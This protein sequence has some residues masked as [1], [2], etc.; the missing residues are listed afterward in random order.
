LKRVYETEAGAV[1]RLAYDEERIAAVVESLAE[2]I[3]A[4]YKGEQLLLI[5]VLKG[6]VV[7]AADLARRLRLPVTLDFVGLSSYR[8]TAST[9]TVRVTR[10]IEAAVAGRHVLVIEDIVDT[11][12]TLGF[13]LEELRAR[14][15]RSLKVCTLIDKRINRKTSFVPDYAG[16]VCEDGFLVGYGLDL[17]E[18]Y[19]QLPA[20][21]EITG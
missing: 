6:A 19:R 10:G 2:T 1:L 16:I 13:L 9:G 8:G 11:G 14:G 17:N 12:L 20:L 18:K 4:D 7:F 21:Y 15:P 3:S 5:V